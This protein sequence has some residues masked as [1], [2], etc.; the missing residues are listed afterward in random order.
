[1]IEMLRST[2]PMRSPGGQTGKRATALPNASPLSPEFRPGRGSRSQG[3]AQGYRLKLLEGKDSTLGSGVRRLLV[4]SR[5]AV[6]LC[7]IPCAGASHLDHFSWSSVPSQAQ[8]GRPFT[9][10]VEARD[11]DGFTAADYGGVGFLSGVVAGVPQSIL[12]NEVETLYTERVEVANVSTA[13]VDVSGW[14]L[15]FYDS[16]S[17]PGPAVTF[18]IPAGTVCA[19]GSVFQ[20]SSQGTA[21]GAYPS[22]QLGAPLYWGAGSSYPYAA[23]ALLDQ[24]GGKVDFF[25]A[26]SAVPGLIMLPLPV[27][28]A[29]WSGPPV[30]ANYNPSLTYQRIGLY[31]HNNAGDWVAATNSVGLPNRELRIPLAAPLSRITVAPASVTFSNGLW[32]GDLVITNPVTNLVLRADDLAGHAGDSR[33]LTILGPQP[34]RVVIPSESFEAAPGFIGFGVVTLPGPVPTNVVVDLVSSDTNEIVVPGDASIAAGLTEGYFALTNLSDGLPDG[35]QVVVVT[36]SAPGFAPGSGFITNYDVGNATLTL[37]LPPTVRE[38]DGWISNALVQVDSAVSADVIVRLASSDTNEIRVPDTVVLSRGSKSTT[39]SFQVL[40]DGRLAGTQHVTVTATVPFWQSASAII[41]VADAATTNLALRVPAQL[42][43]GSGLISLAGQVSISGTVPTNVVVALGN[44]DPARLLMPAMVVIAAGQTAASFTLMVPDDSLMQGA[45]VVTVT[46]SSPGFAAAESALTIADNDVHHLA[47]AAIPSPQYSVQPFQVTVYAKAID[48]QTVTGFAGEA[49]I[50]ARNGTTTPPDLRVTLANGTWTG[51]ITVIDGSTN[52][53]LAASAEGGLVG[54]SNPFRVFR[55]VIRQLSLPTQ[56]LAYDPFTTRL[57]ATVPAS[58]GAFSNSLVRVDPATGNIESSQ[59]IG[60]DPNRLAVSDGGQ[61][62][63]VGVDGESSVRQYE[64]GSQAP[65]PEFS[66]GEGLYAFDL[67]VMPENPEVVAVSRSQFNGFGPIGVAIYDDG[68]E[69]TNQAVGPDVIVFGSSNVLYGYWNYT[70][71]FGFFRM[72]V[73]A[74]GVTVQSSSGPLIPDYAEISYDAGRVYTTLGGVLDPDAFRVLGQLPVQGLVRAY[75]AENRVYVLFHETGGWSLAAFDSTTLELF[76]RIP[77]PGVAGTPSRLLRWGTN[78]LAFRTTGNQ[79]FL[80]ETELVPQPLSA[81]LSVQQAPVVM[82]IPAG[83]NLV[84]SVTLT[85]KGPNNATGVMLQDTLPPGTALVSA[86]ATKGVCGLKENVLVCTLGTMGPGESAAVELVLRTSTAGYLTNSAIVS[87][88]QFDSRPGDNISTC[89]ANVVAAPLSFT[90]GILPLAASDLVWDATSQRLYVTV[91]GDDASFGNR[92]LRMNPVSGQ[93]EQAWFVGSE[94]SRVVLSSDHRYLYVAVDGGARVRRFD[95]T[96]AT[97][98]LSLEL[99]LGAVADDLAPLTG[100]PQSIAITRAVPNRSPSGSGMVV[101]DNN[102]LRLSSDVSYRIEPGEDAATLY[103][104]VPGSATYLARYHLGTNTVSLD[105]AV[106]VH[107]NYYYTGDFEYEAGLLFTT[108][109]ESIYAPSLGL[110][111]IVTNLPPGRTRLVA[112]DVS[113]DRLF[114]L[115]QGNPKAGLYAYARSTLQLLGSGTLGGISGTPSALTCCG[116]N[117]LAFCTTGHQLFLVQTGLLVPTNQPSDLVV[118]QSTPQQVFFST[119]FACSITVSNQGPAVAAGVVLTD[120]LPAGSAVVSANSSQGVIHTTNGLAQCLVGSLAPGATASMQLTLLT[121]EP[122]ALTNSVLA[123]SSGPEL[124]PQDNFSTVALPVSFLS[125]LKLPVNDMVYD[126]ARARIYASVGPS[127][128]LLSNSVVEIDPAN[129]TLGHA[130]PLQDYPGKLAL[131]DDSQFLYVGLGN[132]GGVDRINLVLR[133]N[134]LFFS[135]GVGDNGFRYTAG[136]LAVLPGQPHALAVSVTD[137]G[138]NVNVGVYDDGVRRPKTV[139]ATMYGGIYPIAF[140]TN[141]SVLYQTTIYTFRTIRI[142]SSGATLLSEVG[143]LVPGY[144]INF[145]T[146][147]GLAFFDQGRVVDPMLDTIVTNFPVSGLVAPDLANDRVYFVTGAGQGSWDWRLTLHAFDATT[148]GELWSVPL[149][150]AQ[151]GATRLIKS[152]ASGLALSTD[153]GL[154]FIFHT[155]QLSQPVADVALTQTA[156][157]ASVAAGVNTTCALTVRNLGPSTATGIVVS[158]PV[159]DGLIV[160]AV[161]ASKGTVVQT[162]PAIVASIG[163]LTNSE[164]ATVT[165]ACQGAVPGRYLNQGSV[166]LDQPDPNPLN[167]SASCDVE[168]SPPLF[169]SV[170]DA[171]VSEGNLSSTFS[172]RCSLSATSSL[173]VSV[174]YQTSDGTAVA[175]VDYLTSYGVCTL[176]AGTTSRVVTTLLIRGNALLQSNRF[177]Y[178]DLTAVTNAILVRT[179]AVVTILEDDFRMISATNVALLEGNSGITNAIFTVALSTPSP[180]PVLVDYQTIDGT[181]NAGSDYAARAGTLRFEAGVTNLQLSVPVFGDSVPEMDESFWVLLSDPSGAVLGVNQMR[182]TI[183][184]DDTLPLLAFSGVNW[185]GGDLHLQFPTISGRVYRVERSL[186]LTTPSWSVIAD[187]IQGTGGSINITDSAAP[188]NPQAFYR[189]V[190][191]Q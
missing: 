50:S 100:L 83:S 40:N 124:N 152:G 180:S 39:F 130:I 150:P 111:G 106:A 21:P 177:F 70:T 82:P 110:L 57:Y 146:D 161:I 68:I 37:A 98:D 41:D 184:N 173:P 156:T 79:I 87:E 165:F 149:A 59:W 159:P 109:G 29:D 69:R 154:V 168:V 44:S 113:A 104:Y 125:V 81:N 54:Q 127:G 169:L 142:D 15:V 115:G 129:G 49:V 76:G 101:Y 157:P 58:G 8:A 88:E 25:C 18:T 162:N 77:V 138:G 105:S 85:N 6:L 14:S 47:F 84:F 90:A 19:P 48:G 171:R 16:Q 71:G 143:N 132:T 80:L 60:P 5:V 182:G 86:T 89:V 20:V 74:G 144:E 164:S 45:E 63:Y 186:D 64:L 155:G 92:L 36:A 176:P 139:P 172:L 73:D 1:M 23:V 136:G 151:G 66:V 7:A 140:S 46:G 128:G 67:A 190:L 103:N 2:T 43:E 35:P 32:S 95:L 126:P 93:V 107:A 22:F 120:I 11:I 34:L 94:P 97:A 158:N 51:Q 118:A 78:G 147:R 30:P 178:V 121:H 112:A 62:L 13:P 61:Y 123:I 163:T 185:A 166:A 75:S 96:S 53:S 122:R 24:V 183:V 28:E 135:L 10:S 145:E 134:D 114:A 38:G 191:T 119:P 9:V 91:R 117:G 116:T 189:L 65:G 56:D 27:V 187:G 3:S 153:A 133:T 12:I 99:E 174:R 102:V 141:S 31:D 188:E 167:N 179:Q 33:P 52:V 108:E 148:T 131:S 26:M 4:A 137:F 72:L 42:V 170:E 175:G 17:W 181:A 55:P 160:N